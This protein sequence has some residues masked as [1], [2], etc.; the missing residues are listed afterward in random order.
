M[1]R[2]KPMVDF[3]SRMHLTSRHLRAWRCL[4]ARF[5]GVCFCYLRHVPLRLAVWVVLNGDPAGFF[6]L[7]AVVCT[8]FSAMNIAT[9][10]RSPATPWGR[11]ELLHVA[12]P[13]PFCVASLWHGGSWLSSKVGNCLLSRSVL[14]CFLTTCLNSVWM[15][16]QP[17]SSRLPWFPRMEHLL[18]SVKTW[19]VGWWAKHYGALSPWLG[20]AIKRSQSCCSAK[21]MRMQW[22]SF[23][24]VLFEP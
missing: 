16:E 3:T 10:K 12:V 23:D 9:S 11:T 15:I 14:L 2:T 7:L 22:V 8:S 19:R 21:N 4:A 13:R 1:A 17:A 24:A 18:M 6:L 20:R 5:L